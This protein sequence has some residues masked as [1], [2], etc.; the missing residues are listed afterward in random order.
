M[1]KR[2]TSNGRPISEGEIQNM[3]RRMENDSLT[4]MITGD[5]LVF[6]WHTADRVLVCK[7][8]ESYEKI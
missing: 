1:L 2:V 4:Y 6:H 3:V 5:T 8:V 7:I